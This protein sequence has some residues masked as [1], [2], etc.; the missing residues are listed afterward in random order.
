MKQS[1]DKTRFCLHS[2]VQSAFPCIFCLSTPVCLSEWRQG[3]QFYIKSSQGTF[4]LNGYIALRR[5]ADS[6]MTN[7]EVDP[8]Q[9]TDISSWPSLG[10]G[11]SEK[12]RTTVKDEMYQ[13]TIVLTPRISE[14][15]G[16]LFQLVEPSTL[17]SI[18]EK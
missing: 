9:D 2:Q 4:K 11:T 7:R 10:K 14:S 8:E 1:V 13:A 5:S 6:C 18:L 12:S 17:P 16:M 15:T 3:K